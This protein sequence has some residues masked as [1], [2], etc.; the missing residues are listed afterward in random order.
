MPVRPLEQSVQFAACWVWG[1]ELS[2]RADPFRV[3]FYRESIEGQVEGETG[4]SWRAWKITGRN[5]APSPHSSS[6]PLLTHI[7]GYR[8]LKRAGGELPVGMG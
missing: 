6:A 7:F 1:W 3:T 2:C 4:R 8:I 5:R